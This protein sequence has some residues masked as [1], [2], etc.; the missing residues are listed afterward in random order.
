MMKRAVSAILFLG[1]FSTA[2][3]QSA[4]GEPKSEITY[5]TFQ[6]QPLKN[7]RYQ[8]SWKE[9]SGNCC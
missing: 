7:N 9:F 5:C 6:K 8:A 4:T 2:M 1:S 3:A